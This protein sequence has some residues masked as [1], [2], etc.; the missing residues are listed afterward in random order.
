MPFKYR[1]FISYSHADHDWGVWLHKALE[2]FIIHKN[3]IGTE[4]AVGEAPTKLGRVFR[5]EE[6]LGAA[7]ELGPKIEAALS[8]SDTLIVICSPRSAMS[9]WVDKEIRRFKE[10]G[11]SNR[12]LAVIVDGQP[13][14]KNQ[15]HEC[16]PSSLKVQLDGSPAEPLAVDVRKF[17]RDD[18]ILRLV[19]GILDIDYDEL[20]RRE[21][22][23]AKRAARRFMMF[24]MGA[25]V[26]FFLASIGLYQAI[27][28]K[29]AADSAITSNT[30]A[31]ANA[32]YASEFSYLDQV[33]EPDPTRSVLYA[34]FRYRRN[35]DLFGQRKADVFAHLRRFKMNLYLAGSIKHNQPLVARQVLA[36][37]TLIVSDT[38]GNWYVLEPKKSTLTPISFEHEHEIIFAHFLFDS[39]S[40][41]YLDAV[42]DIYS[43][44]TLGHKKLLSSLGAFSVGLDHYRT[45]SF[46]NVDYSPLD[47]TLVALNENEDQTSE[48]IWVNLISGVKARIRL[49]DF[50]IMNAHS[51]RIL[52]GGDLVAIAANSGRIWSVYPRTSTVELVYDPTQPDNG[53]TVSIK[54]YITDESVIEVDTTRRLLAITSPYGGVGFRLNNLDELKNIEVFGELPYWNSPSE[55][56]ISRIQF[57]RNGLW[58]YTINAAGEL[59]KYLNKSGVVTLEE[60]EP[61]PENVSLRVF[62]NFIDGSIV[63]VTVDGRLLIKRAIFED[64]GSSGYIDFHPAHSNEIHQVIILDKQNLVV[65]FS[66]DKSVRLWSTSPRKPESE[67]LNHHSP[68]RVA[69]Y[70]ENEDSLSVWSGASDGTLQVSNSDGSKYKLLAL[71]KSGITGLDSSRSGAKVAL[72]MESGIVQIKSANDLDFSDQIARTQDSRLIQIK[73][74]TSPLPPKDL[75]DVQVESDRQKLKFKKLTRFES[76]SAPVRASFARFSPNENQLAITYEDGAIGLWDENLNAGYIFEERHAGSLHNLAISENGDYLATASSEGSLVLWSMKERKYIRDFFDYGGCSQRCDAHDVV[77]TNNDK[78]I[79]SA[80][81][82]GYLR[83]WNVSDGTLLKSV[84]ASDELSPVH[85]ISVSPGSQLIAVGANDGGVRLMDFETG[86]FIG[87]L[88]YHSGGVNCVS[89]NNIGD[90]VVTASDDGTVRTWVIPDF[91]L[92]NPKSLADELCNHNLYHKQSLSRHELSML[93]FTKSQTVPCKERNTG[94][95][96]IINSFVP[97]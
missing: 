15:I 87:T 44:S 46:R 65:S 60:T 9:E 48:L 94:L 55:N 58:I 96:R 93:G 18:S 92:L 77:F 88:G 86:L 33:L 20:K 27:I 68:V 91:L 83:Y 8:S 16:F 82:D 35:V 84:N 43:M 38:V 63:F 66:N 30:L 54:S 17:G 59:S 70:V 37:A 61:V 24:F 76:E 85:S 90:H 56:P 79:I 69:V 53:A 25:T 80:H 22:I 32:S 40:I 28:Q 78:M 1:A 31:V 67:L 64:R 2:K 47:H 21:L 34:L 95:E 29:D 4:T 73:T 49:S 89:F 74:G 72:A 97:Y 5:D 12:V 19:S 10:L 75:D 52:N 11:R 26:L 81:H 50:G 42:G 71:E 3:L 13:H 45:S 36:D 6:E 14:S 23:K 39:R 41:L 7:H 57:S 51:V 62:D